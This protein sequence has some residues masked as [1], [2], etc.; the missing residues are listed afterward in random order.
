MHMSGFQKLLGF[1]GSSL[2][3]PIRSN[4][5]IEQEPI[6]LWSLPPLTSFSEVKLLSAHF[7]FFMFNYGLRPD[8]VR[9]MD[10]IHTLVWF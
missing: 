4:L 2:L 3:F 9:F 6:A 8:R 1:Q 5:P 10:L 7:F